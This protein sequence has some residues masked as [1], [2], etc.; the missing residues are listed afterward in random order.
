MSKKNKKQL[1]VAM[2]G[3]KMVPSRVGGIEMV[4]TSL[5]PLLV[6]NGIEV[7]CIN[8]TGVLADEEFYD[9]YSVNEYKGV[10]LK[11]AATIKAKGLAAMSSSFFASVKAAFGRYDIVHY[12]AEGPAAML[13]IPK[14]F[15]KKTVVTV[16]G[17]DWQ[18]EKWQKGFG[19]K[20]IKYGERK[21]AKKADEIIVLS[22][23][24][25]YY[26]KSEYARDTVFIP[27]GVEKPKVRELNELKELFGVESGEYFCCVCRLT[28]EKGVH[29]LIEAYKKLDTDKKLLIVGGSSDTDGYVKR[30]KKMA[31]DNDNI[32]FTGFLGGS[33]LEEAFS[34]A[35]A[36][37]LPSNIE[38]MPISLLEAMSYGNA[39]IVSDI[40]ENTSVIDEMGLS[41]HKGEIEDLKEKMQYLLEH[42]DEEKRL[43]NASSAYILSKY[44]W[45]DVAKETIALYNRVVMG[46]KTIK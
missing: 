21:A 15:G 28:E 32:I 8:R 17:L 14:L 44:N 24:V 9:D 7:T 38:G 33:L 22:E 10:I 2:I 31:E 3:Q 45:N 4:L 37:I 13:W 11:R 26:F 6:E 36:Y 30:I 34:N 18:R 29:Y 40:K 16:H 42:P 41:F 25:K 1:R 5:C 12:H 20:Y 19:R 23:N 39:C 27:N 35:Y 46:K 43:R